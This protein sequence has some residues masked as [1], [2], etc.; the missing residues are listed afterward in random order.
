MTMIPGPSDLQVRLTSLSE[1]A[2]EDRA[3]AGLTSFATAAQTAV[4]AIP[5][6]ALSEHAAANLITSVLKAAGVVGS[7]QCDRVLQMAAHEFAAGDYVP[8][9]PLAY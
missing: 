5:P 6:G 7:G 2:K 3:V 1:I 4:D 9:N 8:G